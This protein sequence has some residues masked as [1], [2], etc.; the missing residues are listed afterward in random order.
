MSEILIKWLNNEIKLSKEVKE[1]SEDFKNGYLFAELL[2]KTKQVQRL[3]NFMNSNKKKDIIHNFCLLNKTLLDMG[4]V[5][6]ERDRNEIMNGGIYASKIYLLK[7]KQVLDKK[8]INLEQLKYKYSN[9]LQLLYNNMCYKSQN[10]KYLY[11]LKVRLEN[12]KN[13]SSLGTSKSVI[14]S[15]RK[16]EDQSIDKKYSLGGPLYKQLKKKY[17]HLE[18]T[19]FDLEIILLDMKEEEIK[20]NYLKEKV[21]KTEKERQNQCRSKEKKEIKNWNSSM[22]EIKK[23]KNN[24]LKESWEPVIKNQK[25]FM[26]YIKKNSLRNEKITNEFDKDLNFFVSEKRNE[27][28]YNEENEINIKKSMDLKNE[29]Y[30]RQIKEK[31]EQKIK[32]KKDREKRER[33]RLKEEREMYERLNTEKNMSDMIKNME[34]NLNKGKINIIKGDELISKTE[35]LLKEVP[36]TE[37]KRIKYLDE[38]INREINKENRIDEEKNISYIGKNP[39]VEMNITK[40]IKIKKEKE[41]KEDKEELENKEEINEFEENKDNMKEIEENNEDKEILNADKSTYSKLTTNDYGLYLINDAFK[42]HNKDININDRIKLFKTRLTEDSEIKYKNLPKLPDIPGIEEEEGNSKIIK[43]QSNILDKSNSDLNAFD[44]ESFFEEMNKLNYENFRKESQKRKMKKEKKNKLMKPILEKIIEI[45]E[46]IYDYQENKGVQLLDNTKWE[47]IMDKFINWE[48]IK[49]NEEDEVISQEEISEYL[50][51]YG[52]KLNENDNLILFDYINYLNI[53]N[54]LI[55]PTTL[56]GKRYKYYELYEEIYNL[57]NNDVDIKDYE[58]NEDEIENLI[59]PKTPNYE[60]YKLYDIIEKVIKIKYKKLENNNLNKVNKTDIYSQKGKYFYLPIKISITGYPMSGKKIQSHLIN[61]KYQNIKIFDPQEILENKIEEY[62]ELKEPVEK[63]TKSKNMKPNQLEQLIKE[64]EDKLNNFKPILNIIQPYLDFIDKNNE[65]DLND[66]NYKEDILTDVYI[67]LLLYELEKVYPDDK[68][69]KI[70]LLEEINE[71]Y[72]QYISTKEQINEIKKNEEENKKEIDDKSNKNKKVTQNYSKDLEILNKQLESI[73]PY[74]YVGFIFINFPKNEIQAKK[75]ENIITGYVSEFEKPK[76]KIEEKL[77]NYDCILDINVKQKINKLPQISMFDLFINLNISSEESEHRYNGCKYDPTTK[78]IYNMEDN[79]P[80]NDKKIIERLLPGIPNFDNKKFNEEKELYE[81]NIQNLINFYK[82]MSNGMKKIYNNIDQMDKTFIHSINNNIEN[83]LEEVILENYY[84]NIELIM[85]NINKSD[86][87]INKNDEN[88]KEENENY[89]NEE[90]KIEENKI[91]ENKIE[92]NI[93]EENKENKNDEIVENKDEK[94][95][96]NKNDENKSDEKENYN[97]YE[98]NN[99]SQKSQLKLAENKNDENNKMEKRLSN[100]NLK[101]LPNNISKFNFSEEITNQFEEFASCYKS[102]LI[103]FI[104]F[105]LRQKEHIISYLTEIQNEFVSYLNR[106]TEKT[107][108]AEIYMNKYN[109][110]INNHKELLNNPKVYNELMDD[111]EDV[112]KS[113]WLNIQNKKNEDV[114]YLKNAKETDKLENELKKFWEYIIILIEAEVK[115]YLTTCEIIIKYY[116]NKT[117]L[118]GN[119]LGIFE[120]NLKI[121][122][123]DEYLF[124]INHLKYLFNEIDIPANLF[125]LN[126]PDEINKNEFNNDK[127]KIINNDNDNDKKIKDNEIIMEVEYEGENNDKNEIIKENEIKDT[128]DIKENK[129]KENIENITKNKLNLTQKSNYSK[130]TNKK[131][132]TIEENLEILFMNSLKII[133]R[134]DLLMKQYK[135]KIKNYN[136]NNEKEVRNHKN[137]VN[138]LVNSSIS[139]RTSRR[140]SNLIKMGKGGIVLFHEELSNQIRIEKQKFKYRLMFLKYFTIKYYNMIIESFNNTFNAMD[141]WIIMSVRAQNNSL[142]EFIFYL[143]KS[144]SKTNKK[145]SL[146][147]FEFDNFDIYR[148]YKVDI[149]FIYEKMNLNS[150]VDLKIKK[151]KKD[152][153]I[154]INEND[155]LYEDQFVYNIFDLMYIYNYL[156]TFGTEGC[157]YLVKYEIVKEIL[158]HHFFSRKKYGDLSNINNLNNSNSEN[159]LNNNE[160][161]NNENENNNNINLIKNTNSSLSNLKEDENNGISKKIKFKSN[162]NYINFLKKFSE[163]NNNYININNL[164]TSL[165]ILG[166]ELISSQKFIEL[167]KEQLPKEKNNYNHILLSKEEFLNLNLWFENDKYLNLYADEKEEELFNEEKNKENNNNEEMTKIKK[168][169]NSIFEINMEDGKIN[170]N[171]IIK[172]LDKINGNKKEEKM[173]DNNKK[174]NNNEEKKEDKKEKE[175]INGEEK[176]EE[177]REEEKEIEN[178]EMDEKKKEEEKKTEN[179]EEENIKEKEEKS[180]QEKEEKE[181][182]KDEEEL[183]NKEEKNDEEEVNKSDSIK[184]DETTTNQNESDFIRNSVTN[185]K[186][187]KK[188]NDIRNNI[189]NALFFN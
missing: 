42:I 178:K 39:N 23:S 68:E 27:D 7:I 14:M 102:K 46:Y 150:I 135:E 88:N 130:N 170:L 71:K 188:K 155:M 28:E 56:R 30:M 19:D 6:N 91:E 140:K 48:E 63:T 187:K 20:L 58:P 60:N 139:S 73:I 92:E 89:K 117:G 120:N 189:F 34:N 36:P 134:Q 83:L 100:N 165:I 52:D 174:E 184:N 183:I 75:L 144:L 15:E 85:N 160:A 119:I 111:I 37:R 133:I 17:S 45:T 166:S 114:I 185:K 44:K 128:Q 179:K 3:S 81:K 32:S 99:D 94:E 59:L 162:I 38:L 156:K 173:N 72:K 47:E 87:T 53:F 145:V 138:K 76:D 131:E 49:D 93:G 132:K 106:K 169:K 24:L 157:E 90:N 182:E 151:K 57:G 141:D 136:P 161:N 62:K 78:K 129:E 103:N 13:N 35:E 11:N 143:R 18:L 142:N 115:K 50:F 153:I 29:I 51:D 80:P 181:K 148:R 171:K 5:L 9:D 31:L 121:N 33:K 122:K 43:N 1:I 108:V 55:I 54:D 95:N 124:K 168:I 154:L 172:L 116:L 22:L 77:Y 69:S 149:S 8:C 25:I 70:K 127:N 79:P 40:L 125:I 167:I 86:N 74:L 4:I 67:N 113:I 66:S 96:I 16:K 107:S 65:N 2:Y 147:D 104:H 175:E 164:F 159:D 101:E 82:I 105:I 10:E 12:E 123:S 126:N 176:E 186:N 98:D 64:R 146:E 26:N 158:I 84:K 137:N 112:S 180:E 61:N 21:Q 110:I 118:L 41:D 177:K 109:S 152:E 97:K 163:Y